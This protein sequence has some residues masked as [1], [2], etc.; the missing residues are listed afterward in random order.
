MKH[1]LL[2]LI[3]LCSTTIYAQSSKV[4]IHNALFNKLYQ[5]AAIQNVMNFDKVVILE[6]TSPRLKMNCGLFSAENKKRF[7]IRTYEYMFLRTIKPYIIIDEVEYIIKTL[8]V[9]IIFRNNSID[10]VEIDNLK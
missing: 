8:N 10:M 9:R 4:E 5:T 7:L 1:R 6:N 3:I 2:F